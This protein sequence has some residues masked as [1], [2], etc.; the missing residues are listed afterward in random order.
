MP[1]LPFVF[2]AMYGGLRS[3]G[4]ASSNY[5]ALGTVGVSAEE[6]AAQDRFNALVEEIGDDG[7]QDSFEQIKG[8]HGHQDQGM[9]VGNGRIDGLPHTDNG[10]QRHTK[11]FG[12]G[13]EYVFIR[14]SFM[15]QQPKK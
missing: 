3:R 7:N 11:E 15:N 2:H 12:K 14:T 9:D 10:F 4:F 8:D 1:R 13:K 5:V 6:K